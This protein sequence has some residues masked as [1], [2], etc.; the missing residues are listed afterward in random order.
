MQDYIAMVLIW[1]A[2]QISSSGN[3]EQLEK[4]FTEAIA[5]IEKQLD[6]AL[7]ASE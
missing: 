2:T 4:E 6:K 5:K 3:N 7:Q 1:Y